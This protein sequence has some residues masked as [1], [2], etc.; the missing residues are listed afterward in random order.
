MYILL[1]QM[2]MIQITLRPNYD[3][4]DNPQ[5]ATNGTHTIGWKALVLGFLDTDFIISCIKPHIAA[6]FL[7]FLGILP[8]VLCPNGAWG[9]VVVKALR[10]YS[11]GP[12]IHSRWCHW[13][14][15]P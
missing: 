6:N 13:G 3:V 10:Y 14:F 7:C 1:K 4:D 5:I 11:D 2:V 9:S 15:F 12:G 8:L